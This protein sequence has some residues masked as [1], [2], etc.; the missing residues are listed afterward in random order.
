MHEVSLVAAV[1]E[2]VEE[3]AEREHFSR[4]LAIRLSVGAL[5]GVDPAC[6]EFCFS[7]VTRAT[8]LEGARLSLDPVAVEVSCEECGQRSRPEDPAC[9]F[10]A[11]C[12]STLVK[13]V[14]GRDFRIVDLEVL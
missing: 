7:E 2:Q 14:R 11:H 9:L 3:A 8:V 13:V 4:V 10:C 5:S 6:L 12:G 1:V